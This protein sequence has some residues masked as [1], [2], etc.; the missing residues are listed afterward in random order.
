VVEEQEPGGPSRWRTWLRI[1]CAY[2]ENEA[3]A[4]MARPMAKTV[5]QRGAIAGRRTKSRGVKEADEQCEDGGALATLASPPLTA[6]AAGGLEY[7]STD[8]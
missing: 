1:R 2:G 3:D 4:R 6:S 8:S 5:K 7:A